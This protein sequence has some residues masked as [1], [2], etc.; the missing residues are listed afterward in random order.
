WPGETKLKSSP[1]TTGQAEGGWLQWGPDNKI[2]FE[3]ADFHSY[4]MNPDGS[5]RVRVPDRETNAA[6]PIS[7]GSSAIVFAQLR[8]NMLNLFRQS[9]AN[10]EIKQLT[11]E[12]DAEWPTCTRDG[13]TVYYIDNLESQSLKRV[14]TNG[15]TPE[16]VAVGVADGV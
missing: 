7:C 5:S 10:G 12:H 15:G 11:S 9:L 4:R 8:D 6:Y 13:K 14:S 16:L 1:I 3:D 2:Y